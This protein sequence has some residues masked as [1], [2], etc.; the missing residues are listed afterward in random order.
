MA[1]LP[2]IENGVIACREQNCRRCSKGLIGEGSVTIRRRSARRKWNGCCLEVNPG[3]VQT[4]T[5]APAIAERCQRTRRGSRSSSTTRLVC[6][7]RASRIRSARTEASGWICRP[8]LSWPKGR[9]SIKRPAR[10]AS[11]VGNAQQSRLCGRLVMMRTAGKMN[12]SSHRPDRALAASQRARQVLVR[13]TPALS[14]RLSRA[15]RQLLA[16]FLHPFAKAKRPHISPYFINIR[17][18]FLLLPFPARRFPA[19]R[20]RFVLRP[21]R[22][23]LLAIHHDRIQ[24]RIFIIRKHEVCSSSVQNYG[25]VRYLTS[26]GT[27]DYA[28]FASVKI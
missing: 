8:K 11:P 19:C 4:S 2:R 24:C 25:I 20:E 22:E 18:A 16:R 6:A 28:N 21:N 13:S 14:R 9:E 23:L 3:W 26:D 15:G 5:Q 10:A 12:V 1:P 7:A 27:S 17:Q